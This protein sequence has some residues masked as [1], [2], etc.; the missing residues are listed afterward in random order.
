MKFSPRFLTITLL[1]IAAI[2]IIGRYFKK[3]RDAEQKKPLPVLVSDDY[4]A[5]TSLKSASPFPIGASIDDKLIVQDSSYHKLVLNQ[6]NSV[7]PENALKWKAVEQQQGVLDFSRADAIVNFAL[8]NGFR[9]HGHVLITISLTSLPDWIATFKGDSLAWENLFKNHI[10]A[11]VSHYRGKIN[12]WD[13]VNET[14]DENGQVRVK[15]QQGTADN[16]WLKHLGKDYTA[17][18]FIYAHEADPDALLFY[19]DNNQ[20]SSDGKLNAILA[21][22]RDFKKRNIPINGLGVQMHTNINSSDEGIENAFKVLAGTG[23]KI[24]VSELDV[25][26]NPKDK[27]YID[28]LDATAKQEAKYYLIANAYKKEV[29]AQQQYGINFWNVTDKDSWIVLGHHKHDNPL[30]FDGN[31]KRKTAYKYFISGLKN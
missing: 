9:V 16:P 28:T 8:K 12:S 31:Y 24:H 17:R 5:N 3:L 2:F 4:A 25:R 6:F 26:I 19:N 18:A 10:Q 14:Y 20:E 13:V 29:P 7:T 11:L 30:L 27:S 22:V 21:M 15:N 23:L 1:V